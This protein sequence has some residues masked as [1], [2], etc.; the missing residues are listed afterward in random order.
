MMP[1]CLKL[2]TK[3]NGVENSSGNILLA[4]NFRVWLMTIRALLEM[5]IGSSTVYAIQELI[6]MSF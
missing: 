3:R 6:H 5:K 4:D 1:H 2:G